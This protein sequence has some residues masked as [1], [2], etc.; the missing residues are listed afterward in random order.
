MTLLDSHNLSPKWEGLKEAN[1][2]MHHEKENIAKIRG[3]L[4]EARCTSGLLTSHSLDWEEGHLPYLEFF[5]NCEEKKTFRELCCF[6]FLPKSKSLLFSSPWLE[7]VVPK[8]ISFLEHSSSFVFQK[9]KFCSNED[10]QKLIQFSF[11]CSSVGKESA[12][13]AGDLGSIPGSGRPPGEGNGFSRRKFTPV[14]LPGE[15]H[16]HRSLVGCSP[17]GRKESGMTKQLLLA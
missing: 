3:L 10:I 1:N 4:W 14:S 13:S 5:Q 8:S 2:H 9:A 11:P 6:L 12:G 16:E 17:C 7:K 15:S